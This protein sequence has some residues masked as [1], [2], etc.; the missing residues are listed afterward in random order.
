MTSTLRRRIAELATVVGVATIV[1]G[2][3]P[4]A[5]TT[6]A[7]AVS[8]LWSQFLVAAADPGSLPKRLPD[9]A[10]PVLLEIAEATVDEPRGSRRR[11]DRDVV[12]LHE[13]DAEAA[14]RRVE[15][16]PAPDDPTTDDEHVEGSGR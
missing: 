2:C 14:R 15:G 13:A 5:R 16:R 11:P 3:L 7:E 4:A 6:Q 9:E 1:A 8:T 12:L 10:K